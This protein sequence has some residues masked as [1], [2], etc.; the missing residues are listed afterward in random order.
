[1][2]AQRDMRRE[3]RLMARMKHAHIVRMLEA[4]ASQKGGNEG[5]SSASRF[6]IV[7]EFARGGNL[8][9]FLQ[10]KVMREVSGG[11][12]VGSACVLEGFPPIFVGVGGASDRSVWLHDLSSS[13]V[14]RVIASVVGRLVPRV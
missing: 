1:M 6:H 2:R 9:S 12:D 3:V 8:W 7:M 13:V 11:G 14:V 5:H 4:F 10:S